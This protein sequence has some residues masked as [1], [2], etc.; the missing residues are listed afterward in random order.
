M[1]VDEAMRVVDAD[2]GFWHSDI[3][4]ASE[5]LSRE[6]KRLRWEVDLLASVAS[7][8]NDLEEECH[9]LKKENEELKI[10]WSKKAERKYAEW[11]ETKGTPCKFCLGVGYYTVCIENDK[12]KY[13]QI[14]NMTCQS[15]N[16]RGLTP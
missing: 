7:K 11:L 16:G 15:C 8:A 9:K 6:V 10:G 14:G 1:N 5:V 3:S 12:V 13:P 4:L 2:K